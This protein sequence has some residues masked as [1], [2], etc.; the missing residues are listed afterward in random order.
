MEVYEILDEQACRT[1]LSAKNKGACLA[2]L[3]RMM[4][5]VYEDLDEDQVL[6]ELQ[7]RES[8]G[9]T[10]FGG[11]VAIPHARLKNVD[12]FHLG[13]AVSRRGIDFQS[14]DK[15]KTFVFF[16]IVGAADKP[17]EYLQLLAQIS[18]VGKNGGAL[19]ELRSARSSLALKE[20]FVRNVREAQQPRSNEGKDKLFVVVLYE[21][22][23]LEEITEL[24]L[25]RG[26]RGASVMDSSGIR[27][28]LSK[29]PLFG[30]FLNFLGERAEMSKT[31]M[32]VVKESEIPRLVEGMEEIMGD[33]DTHSGAMVMAL[34]IA[35]M[36]GSLEVL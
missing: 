8:Q 24:F 2:E 34:D 32:T 1:S 7:S 16:I 17:Q 28:V 15:K 20:A 22:R 4:S 14:L 36:K 23:Y 21:R 29:V 25:E 11:G 27:D 31:I 5:S 9:S 10:G 6:E 26:I 33:L 35:Y 30:D 13:L 3:A 18:R 12:T 19:R